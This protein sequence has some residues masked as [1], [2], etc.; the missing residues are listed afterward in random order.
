MFRDYPKENNKGCP[1]LQQRSHLL[2]EPKKSTLLENPP[3]PQCLPSL[4]ATAL[5]LLI[6][7]SWPKLHQKSPTPPEVKL[8][9]RIPSPNCS[10]VTLAKPGAMPATRSPDPNFC[11]DPLCNHRTLQAEEERR[12]RNQR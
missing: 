2:L 9:S 11:R 6:S 4:L 5:P 7:T 8:A 1:L 10:R 12:N 3:L